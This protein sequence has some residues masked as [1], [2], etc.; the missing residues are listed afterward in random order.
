MALRMLLLLLAA[1]ALVSAGSPQAL[2]GGTK[3]ILVVY[4]SHSGHTKLLAE[5]IGVGARSDQTTVK[6][7]PT[8]ETSGADLLSADAIIIGSP[9]YFGSQASNFSAW[10]ETTWTPFWQHG[11]LSTKKGAV[12]TTGGGFAQGIEHVL[13]ELI[14]RLVHF[15]V[16]VIYP[17]QTFGGGYHS[18]GA[19][20]V[21][22]TP[23][24]NATKG[25]AQV[26][27]DAGQDLGRTM[28]RHLTAAED[29]RFEL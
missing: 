6:V 19:I 18:Y 8:N 16:D 24:W 15:K 25:V 9:T 14:R 1:A 28:V 23:P 5:A 21:T 11:N 29:T 20:A 10:I 27:L 17:D 3:E 13:A 22:G 26:F 7:Q 12:F 4:Y 2:A